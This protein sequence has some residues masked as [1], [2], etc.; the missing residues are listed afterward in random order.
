M[1]NEI[2]KDG[3]IHHYTYYRCSRKNKAIKCYEP[4]I[5]EELL[6]RQLSSLL[7]PYKMSPDWATEISNMADRDEKE[8]DQSVTATIQK[9]KAEIQITSQKPQRLLDAYLEQN[10]EREAYRSEKANLLSRKKSL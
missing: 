8:A 10:I 7:E 2:S 5:R 9:Y 6:D 1:E 4:P 3:N